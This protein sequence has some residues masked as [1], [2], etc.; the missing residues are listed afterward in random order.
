MTRLHT[1]FPFPR[2]LTPVVAAAALAVSTGALAN[3][4][5]VTRAGVEYDPPR[6]SFDSVV[7]AA[8]AVAGGVLDDVRDFGEYI[9]M[10]RS[11]MTFPSVSRAGVEYVP[12]VW[13][14]ADDRPAD[15]DVR[16]STAL[17]LGRDS[18]VGLV[19]SRA[20]IEYVP[21]RYT[22]SEV[23]EAVSTGAR[24][25]FPATKAQTG[26]TGMPPTSR[27]GVEYVPPRFHPRGE[28][29][30]GIESMDSRS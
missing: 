3:P 8:K 29:G 6:I 27:A 23:F 14:A 2:A 9:A 7:D 28:A 1:H 24:N 4:A 30:S 19:T 26:A 10:H 5:S 21:A 18:G 12:P 13:G 17:T 25:A 22:W 15:A 20:G 16:V 11:G